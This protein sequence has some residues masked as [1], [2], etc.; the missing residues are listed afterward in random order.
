MPE[1][2]IGSVPP[3]IEGFALPILC[4]AEVNVGL[5]MEFRMKRYHL[6]GVCLL[7]LGLANIAFAQD[8][9]LTEDE[10][11]LLVFAS[12][13]FEATVAQDGFAVTS[14][15][16]IV[17]NIV[18]TTS[19]GSTTSLQ[20]IDQE[21]SGQLQMKPT[22]AASMQLHQVLDINTNGQSQTLDQTVEMI[23]LPDA[24]YMR[25]PSTQPLFAGASFPKNWVNLIENPNAFPGSNLINAEQYL[26]MVQS[27]LQYQ[28]DETTVVAITELASETVD[29]IDLRVIEIQLDFEVLMQSEQMRAAMGILNFEQMGLDVD[30]FLE[31][32]DAEN[33]IITVWINPDDNLIYQQTSQMDMTMQIGNLFPGITSGT[34]NQHLE[35]STVYGSYNEAFTIEAPD[36]TNQ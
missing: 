32:M 7:L 18:A 33:M 8:A 19:A 21:I 14:T 10:Q 5:I 17:Q 11:E 25:F 22:S 30:K 20:K 16:H 26:N 3:K 9:A 24:F 1:D 28:L 12:D 34:L 23:L 4:Y 36:M 15:N 31:S 2:D 13:A 6:L 27:Q 29:G 35:Q